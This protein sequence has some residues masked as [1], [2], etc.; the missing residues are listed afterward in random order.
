MAG[1]LTA[2]KAHNKDYKVTLII[3]VTCAN[4]T[5]KTASLNI[6]ARIVILKSTT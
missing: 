1:E 5:K 2:T 4:D 6:L 3:A